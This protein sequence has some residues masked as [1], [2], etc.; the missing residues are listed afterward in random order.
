MKIHLALHSTLVYLILIIAS[1]SIAPTHYAPSPGSAASAADADSLPSWNDGLAKKTGNR[2][3]SGSTAAANA[4]AHGS[5]A[6]RPRDLLALV[7]TISSVHAAESARLRVVTSTTDLASLV[8]EVGGNR[9]EVTSLALGYE[10]PHFVPVSARSLI[11]L[12]RADLLIV[13][14][15]EME[16]AWLGEGLGALSPLVQCQNPRIRFGSVGYFDVSRYVQVMEVPYPVTRGQGIHPIGNPHYW[17]DP[18]NG[19]RISQAIM[20]KLSAM[21]PNDTSYFEQRFASFSLRISDKERQ[22]KKRMKPYRG[23]KVVSYHRAWSNFLTRFEVVS[24]GEIEPLPGVP[25]DDTHTNLLVREMKRQ[26]VHVILIEPSYKL[27]N[28]KRIAADTGAK[29]LVVPGSVGGVKQ[30]VDYFS[31]IEYNVE[32]LIKAFQ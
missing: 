1:C 21:R 6:A 22:W 14:G 18:E 2:L 7:G 28:A 23:Y 8:R 30:A 15:L 17:L 20:A 25:P 31:L 4:T 29:V 10:D 24:I 13:I 12:N 11:K 9:V 26:N 32:S 3:C 5:R 19:R 27:T 16:S